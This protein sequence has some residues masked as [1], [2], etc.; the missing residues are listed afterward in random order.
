MKVLIF[1]SQ[2]YLLGGA[3]KLAVE[4]A[5]GLVSQP[6]V[7]VDLLC[8]GA[9]DSPG[10]AD[11]KQRLLDS[12]VQSVSFLG[13]RP[14]TSGHGMWKYILKLRRILQAGDYDFI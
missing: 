4:L 14:G 5:E 7:R 1:T 12:G 9:E 13:R 11:T 6:G 8:M 10:T 3:E 2:I